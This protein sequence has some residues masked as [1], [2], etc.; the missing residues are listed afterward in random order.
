MG[1]SK[2]QDYAEADEEADEDASEERSE[3]SEQSE[4]EDEVENEDEQS[5]AQD[6][7]GQSKSRSQSRSKRAPPLEWL[8]DERANKRATRPHIRRDNSITF[9][10]ARRASTIERGCMTAREDAES[11]TYPFRNFNDNDSFVIP[12]P[13][14]WLQCAGCRGPLRSD[15]VAEQRVQFRM[16]EY[17]HENCGTRKKQTQEIFSGTYTSAKCK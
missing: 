4:R 7:L 17:L 1:K 15:R 5:E 10:I 11:R 13:R 9:Y 14:R 16:T 2:E 3:E 8:R 12:H 6:A